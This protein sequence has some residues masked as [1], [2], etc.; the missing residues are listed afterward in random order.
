MSV[1]DSVLGLKSFRSCKD[2]TIPRKSMGK[3]LEAGRNAPSPGN[4]QSLEFIVVE[5][6]HKKEFLSESAG[7]H[8]LEEVPTAVII[9]GDIDRMSRRFS[10]HMAREACNAEAACAVQNMRLVAEEEGIGSCWIGGFDPERVSEQFGV[11][12]GKEPLDILG[13][14]FSLDEVER[15]SKFGL[16]EVC[17]YD[18][19]G[20]QVGSAF[21]GL[22]W[23]GLHEEREIY[24]K[25]AGGFLTKLR[26]RAN[27]YL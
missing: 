13:F 3:V 19:Y 14:G 11:P 23:K 10:D 17:F 7:D 16:N 26:K 8:R 1:F 18:G 27:K 24:G 6:E 4:V 25:K 5:D 12:T 9:L 20:N 22:E 2:D 15:P 21:D